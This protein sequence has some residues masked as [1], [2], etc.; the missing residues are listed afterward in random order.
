MKLL[1]VGCG[2]VGAEVLRQLPEGCTAYALT[3]TD[4]R[5]EEIESNG[6]IPIVGDWTQSLPELSEMDYVLVAVPHREV[7]DLAEETHVVGLKNLLGALGNSWQ[8]L[9]YLSTTGVFG[10]AESEVVDEDT[11]PTPTRIGPKIA[12]R[13]ERFLAEQLPPSRLT[14]LRLAGIYGPG[15]IPLA[16]KLRSG[17]P[18]A[19]P[20]SGFLNLVHVQDIARMVMT[21][22][23]R[24][25]ERACYV[26]SD[27]QPV[28]RLEFYEYLAE[29]CGVSEPKFETPAENDTRARRATSKRVNPQRIVS[30]TGFEYSFPDYREGLKDSL[31]R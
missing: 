3:R 31:S 27:G 8:K 22:L 7:G 4:S 24:D 17:E 18:L 1:I 12:V 16:A 21:V 9:V 5:T 25:L 11:L 29:L 6:A 10:T 20:Q 13:A 30:E 14:I 23:S 26:F 2:Y 28:K 15:R 19:V